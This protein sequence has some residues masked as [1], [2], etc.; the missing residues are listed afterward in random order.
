L[1]PFQH[2]T[3]QLAAVGKFIQTGAAPWPVERTLLTTG[4]LDA[5]LVSK[6]DGGRIVETP[7]LQIAYQS[8]WNW[9]QTLPPP[10]GRP[11]TA[12]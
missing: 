7:W 1:R 12:Q 3:A 8:A 2:F 4:A 5:I 9:Q 6:R 10:P 11:I